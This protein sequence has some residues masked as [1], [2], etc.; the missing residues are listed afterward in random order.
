MKAITHF[1]ITGNVKSAQVRTSQQTQKQ[2]GTLRVAIDDDVDGYLD[3]MLSDRGDMLDRISALRPGDIVC[4]SGF[5]NAREQQTERGSFFNVSLS[6]WSLESPALLPTSARPQAQRPPSVQRAPQAESSRAAPQPT[7]S[8]VTQ[9]APA[10]RAPQPVR[11]DL[12]QRQ[13]RNPDLPPAGF[14]DVS[15]E[16]EDLPF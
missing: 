3:V 12:D 16:D 1:S 6:G 10:D 14:P 4:V 11:R 2:Y 15:D 9:S 13:N 5:L 8:N 7:R